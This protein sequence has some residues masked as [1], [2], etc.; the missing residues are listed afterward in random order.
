MNAALKSFAAASVAESGAVSMPVDGRIALRIHAIREDG[1]GIRVFDLHAA[2]LAENAG[3]SLPPWT[4][5]AHL[6]LSLPNGLERCY[7]LCNVPGE[8]RFYRIAVKRESATRGGSGWLHEQA[9]V[10]MQLSSGAP[11]NAFPLQASE[12]PPVLFA[13]G[14]G[15]TPIYA[16]AADLLHRGRSV[17]LHYFARSLQHAAFLSALMQPGMAPHCTLHL[18]LDAEAVAA[19]LHKALAALARNT[20]LYLCGPAPFIAQVRAQAESLGWEEADIHFELFAA[21][22]FSAPTPDEPVS[23]VFELVLQKSGVRCQVLPGQ[24]IVDA[25]AQAGVEIGT[26]CGEGFCGSCQSTVLEGVPEHR[27]SVLSSRER[28]AGNCILPCVSRCS[29]ARLVLDL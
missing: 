5:G 13:A 11:Q 19:A 10:G 26:S 24:S 27:D 7:S 18:G 4:P 12:V 9:R 16:M 21:A 17:Q 20:P 8:D 28:A 1:E 3:A 2:N 25:A 6:K 23:S 15:I 22:P 14:I 29:S